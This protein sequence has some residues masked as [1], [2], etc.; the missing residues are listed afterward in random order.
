M[1][2]LITWD[3]SYALNIP[4]IDQQHKKWVGLLNALH[5][6][7]F[8]YDDNHAVLDNLIQELKEYTIYHLK[9]EEELFDRYNY[10]HAESH[11]KEHNNLTNKILELE[12]NPDEDSFI[13]NTEA[14]NIAKDWIINHILTSD[15]KY[16]KFLKEK[17]VN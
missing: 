2:G 4:S 1:E 10:P 6:S 13:V 8:E 16:E 15:K 17:G 5:Q 3:D 11:K 9:Y 7:L 12:K 14:F